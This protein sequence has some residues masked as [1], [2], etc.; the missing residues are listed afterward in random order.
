MRKEVWNWKGWD[1]TPTP[2]KQLKDAIDNRLDLWNVDESFIK[3]RGDIYEGV[4]A[5]LIDIIRSPEK[6]SI[7]KLESIEWD[8]HDGYVINHSAGDFTLEYD[9]IDVWRLV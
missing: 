7:E 8:D 4:T 3:Y 6:F 2:S 9:H 5:L 1:F